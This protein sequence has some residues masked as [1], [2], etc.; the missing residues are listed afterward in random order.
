MKSQKEQFEEN[1]LALCENLKKVIN[2]KKYL[3]NYDLK[4]IIATTSFPTKALYKAKI[5]DE[6][7][8]ELNSCI[9]DTNFDFYSVTEKLDALIK[10][11]RVKRESGLCDVLKAVCIL[12]DRSEVQQKWNIE[13]NNASP[14]QPEGMKEVQ[15]ALVKNTGI[16][17]QT[18]VGR[19]FA[20][21]LEDNGISFYGDC[22]GQISDMRK[23]IFELLFSEI[24]KDTDIKNQLEKLSSPEGRN[25]D[26]VGKIGQIFKDPSIF[27]GYENEKSQFII[28]TFSNEDSRVSFVN[29]LSEIFASEVS[30]GSATSAASLPGEERDKQ[31]SGP[32]KSDGTKDKD[33]D[34]SDLPVLPDP[35]LTDAQKKELKL[36]QQNP[37]DPVYGIG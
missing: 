16:A 21:L 27:Y 37:D 30:V 29:R 18:A 31:K 14:S 1:I 6:I 22:K 17:L 9:S 19:L 3:T 8:E 4:L 25:A 5:P 11:D 33:L 36:R 23:R 20:K 10:I 35:E 12:L 34:L 26:L 7:L 15:G 24:N 32:Q 28:M 13:F 2:G